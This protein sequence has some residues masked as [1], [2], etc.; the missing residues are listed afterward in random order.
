MVLRVGTLNLYIKNIN[1]R[2]DMDLYSHL[3]GASH[4]LEQKYRQEKNELQ[5]LGTMLMIKNE[6]VIKLLNPTPTNK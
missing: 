5:L 4:I 3:I 2:L 1:H 6:F